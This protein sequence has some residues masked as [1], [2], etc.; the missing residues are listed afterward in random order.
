[1][2]F[3][4][5]GYIES[6]YPDG[7]QAMDVS[8]QTRSP[9]I[10][11]SI[12]S[13]L[14]VG[15]FPIFRIYWTHYWE[16]TTMGGAYSHAP[17]ALLIF[18]FLIWRKRR[19]LRPV[20]GGTGFS[21]RWGYGLLVCGALLKIFG[22]LHDYSVLRGMTLIPILFGILFIRYPRETCKGLLYPVLFLLFIIPIPT[23]VIDQITLPLQNAT[24]SLVATTMTLMDYE[25][26]R[27]GYI[28]MIE[29]LDSQSGFHEFII[30]QDC[31][32]IRFMVALF[33][34]GTLYTHLRPLSFRQ[35]F[36]MIIM[37]VPLSIL[38]NFCRVLSTVL[39]VIYVD[40]V[41]AEKFFH[42]FSGVL[43]FC[44]TLA[45]L[46]II[47]KLLRRQKVPPGRKRAS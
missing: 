31:S 6:R 17:V 43:V 33:G 24:T 18:F 45:G 2:V 27:Y 41:M 12:A 32:G 1:V 28:L 30:N 47:E 40:P 34:L 46:F 10:D 38:G 3:I 44:C 11:L 25:V 22:E 19:L 20:D 29:G 42:D 16:T 37:I 35:K 36:F 4:L 21:P 9:L 23:F 8:H 14:F 5:S 7:L 26:S 39:L 15:F 13:L